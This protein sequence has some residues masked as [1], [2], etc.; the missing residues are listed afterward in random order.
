M[1]RFESQLTKRGYYCCSN[2]SWCSRQ[3][4]LSGG[5]ARRRL[6]RK[7]RPVLSL[8]VRL[9]EVV[10]PPIRDVF[11][12]DRAGAVAASTVPKNAR[13]EDYATATCFWTQS[14]EDGCMPHAVLSLSGWLFLS[15]SSPMKEANARR[16]PP[17]PISGQHA[18]Y[19]YQI[20]F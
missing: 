20:L 16:P 12:H 13:W 6:E 3:K 15:E 2:N 18:V 17:P 1:L 8:M 14:N 9:D 10:G 11:G 19:I 7:A 4:G 5:G